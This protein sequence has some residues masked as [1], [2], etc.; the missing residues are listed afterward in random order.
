MSQTEKHIVLNGKEFILIGTAHISPESIN[1]VSEVIKRETP[2]YVAIELDEDRLKTLRNPESWKKLDIIKVLKEGRGFLMMANLV[3]SSFQRRMGND[4][5]VKPGEEMKTA[6]SVA[7]ELGIKTA[8]IDR[9][10]TTT[11][12]RAWAKNSL[13]G[14]CKLL[15]ALISSAFT[16]EEISAEEIEEL[17]NSNEMDNMM[18]ELAGY[19]PTVKEVLIDERNEYLASHMYELEGKKIVAVLGAGHLPG[20][21]EYLKK[22][23]S[24]EA[25]TDTTQ[26]SLVPKGGIGGKIM[27]WLFPALMV[28]LVAAG[29]IKG[30]PHESIAALLR[31]FGWNAALAG[32]GTVLAGGHPFAILAAIVTAP[33]GT[34]SPVLGVGMFAGIAQAYVCKPRVEDMETLYDDVTS[35][36]TIYK[37]R[38]LRVLLVFFLSQIGGA[39]GNFIGVAK[40][41]A[42][43]GGAGNQAAEALDTTIVETIAQ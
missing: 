9:P 18:E 34:I 25:T 6:I 37:N 15:A 7:E 39:V 14:K 33:I 38:I 1:E 12:K 40:M 2:D 19:L 20:V 8:M 16:K 17:K 23:A 32:V 24:G 11:L 22:L 3:L 5:G 35:L 28:A 36:K 42:V 4:V 26:I 41:A 27:N 21:E 30:V 13:W 29:F 31:W 10:I 43:V